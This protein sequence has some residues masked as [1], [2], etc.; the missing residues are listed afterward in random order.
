MELGSLGQGEL[1]L[2]MQASEV[3]AVVAHSHYVRI[4]GT[5]PPDDLVALALDL[6]EVP[7]GQLRYLDTP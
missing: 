3:R 7:G 2:S 1:I 6:H 4:V 5:V